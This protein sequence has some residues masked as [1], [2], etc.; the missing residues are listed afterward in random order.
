VVVVVVVVIKMGLVIGGGGKL[1]KPH[2]IKQVR[3]L[4]GQQG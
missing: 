4:F 1:S 2:E 3:G